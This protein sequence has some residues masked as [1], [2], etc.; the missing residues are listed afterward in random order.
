MFDDVSMFPSLTDHDVFILSLIQQRV[1]GNFS[2]LAPL[3][4]AWALTFDSID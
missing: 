3:S 1:A 2:V 4:A